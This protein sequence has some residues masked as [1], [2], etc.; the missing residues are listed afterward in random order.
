MSINN[1]IQKC[2]IIETDYFM[3]TKSFFCFMS[4]NEL[5]FQ[6]YNVCLARGFQTSRYCH[7]HGVGRVVRVVVIVHVTILRTDPDQAD[8]VKPRR[9][10][11]DFISTQKIS[12]WPNV[13][14]LG[15]LLR[16]ATGTRVCDRTVRNRLHASRLKACR[17][18]VGVPLT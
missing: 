9:G 7:G 13:R 10:K 17:P 3:N 4:C 2:L 1:S 14:S 8:R 15:R 12:L 5:W 6:F 16:N 18:Y 11:T